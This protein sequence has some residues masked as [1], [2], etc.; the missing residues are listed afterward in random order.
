MTIS[1]T[2]FPEGTVL[3]INSWTAHYNT[4]VF[5][6]DAPIFRPERWID[7]SPDRLKEMDNYYMPFGLGSRTC[8]GRHISELEMY[9]LIPRLVRDFDFELERKGEW[10]SENYWFVKPTD[11]NVKV[12]RR[13]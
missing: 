2:F 11:F 10:K 13:S 5:G 4:S 12:R 3:G 9:K 6:Q 7:S 8:M 1:N